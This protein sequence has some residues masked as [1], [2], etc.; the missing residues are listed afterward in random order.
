M[1]SYKEW[2]SES[3]AVQEEVGGFAK[4]TCHI[5]LEGTPS[6]S[7]T[8]S[9]QSI[10]NMD[11]AA[12]LAHLAKFNFKGSATGRSGYGA[13]QQLALNMSRVGLMD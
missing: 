6:Q 9:I 12:T 5:V 2:A 3:G 7:Y 1:K 10:D 4:T 11:Q 8:A 13:L